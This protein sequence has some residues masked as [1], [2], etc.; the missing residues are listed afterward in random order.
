MRAIWG[1]PPVCAV[2]SAA[3][4]VPLEGGPSTSRLQ[5]C[6]IADKTWLR[7]DV[8]CWRSVMKPGLHDPVQL[9]G[10][11]AVGS[12]TRQRATAV[13]MTGGQHLASGGRMAIT[14][15]D[16]ALRAGVSIKTV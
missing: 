1:F 2:R 11:A 4:G 13:A 16:V 14:L 12:G 15:H 7:Y 10:V 9:G 8:A 6:I 5:R 3:A